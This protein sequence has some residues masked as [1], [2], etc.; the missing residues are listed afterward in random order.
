[1]KNKIQVGD[2]VKWNGSSDK[3]YTVLEIDTNGMY[4]GKRYLVT[5]PSLLF[6]KS[7]MWIQ[8]FEIIQLFQERDL[9]K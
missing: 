8:N 3:L 7:G 2:K 1:M 4:G 9:T 6:P 5:H